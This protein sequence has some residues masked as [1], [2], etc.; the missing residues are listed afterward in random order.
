MKIKEHYSR[1]VVKAI[2]YRA[3]ILFTDSLIIFFAT[4]QY[5]TT[6]KVIAWSNLASTVLYF[7][8]ERLWDNIQ[9][10]KRKA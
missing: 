7:C 4:K 10:G 3:I 8:H 1:S 6:L 9:W 2:T 5:D